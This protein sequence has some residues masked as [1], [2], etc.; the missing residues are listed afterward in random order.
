[1]GGGG[2]FSTLEGYHDLCVC[3]G[4]RGYHGYTREC[5]VHRRDTMSTSG[6]IMIHVREQIDKSV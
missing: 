5:S 3:G 1:M 2:V 4:G 6:G